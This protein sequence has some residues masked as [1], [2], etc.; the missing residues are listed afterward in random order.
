MIITSVVFFW[1]LSSITSHKKGYLAFFYLQ[2]ITGCTAL[3]ADSCLDHARLII[4]YIKNVQYIELLN[5]LL[6]D[7]FSKMTLSIHNRQAQ[8]HLTEAV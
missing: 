7:F 2:G 8:G 3:H 6:L 4:S 5:L 1:Y